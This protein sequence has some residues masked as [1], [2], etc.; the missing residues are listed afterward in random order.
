MLARLRHGG[1]GSFHI[2]GRNASRVR[3]T[4]LLAIRGLHQHHNQLPHQ[5][6][7]P[8]TRLAI[9]LTPIL[10]TDSTSAPSPRRKARSKSISPMTLILP[11]GETISGT[12]ETEPAGKDEKE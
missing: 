4:S 9:T 2:L 8:A 5:R 10:P 6:K 12:V 3:I 11:C 1:R 7:M